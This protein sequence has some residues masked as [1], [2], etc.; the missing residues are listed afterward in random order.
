LWLPYLAP[1][2]FNIDIRVLSLVGQLTI[3]IACGLVSVR[4]A[5]G[6]RTARGLSLLALAIATALEPDILGFHAIGHTQVYWPLLLALALLLS[7]SHW[8]GALI[9]L[10]LLVNARQTFGACVPIVLMAM[11]VQKAMTPGRLIAFI[12]ALA[13]PFAPFLIHD[14]SGLMDS[15][16]VDTQNRQLIDTSKPTITD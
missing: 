3:P 2:W 12:L 14:A 13:L 15:A 6:G 11:Y 9:V 1:R 8:F 16:S 7:R 5:L 10:G 4:E